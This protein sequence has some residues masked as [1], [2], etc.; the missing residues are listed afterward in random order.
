MAAPRDPPH[1]RQPGCPILRSHYPP[2]PQAVCPFIRINSSTAAALTSV[3][4]SSPGNASWAA[5]HA[6]RGSKTR[7][8][9]GVR[10]FF[11]SNCPLE[12]YHF[13]IGQR[14]GEAQIQ[15]YPLALFAFPFRHSHVPLDF[16]IPLLCSFVTPSRSHSSPPRFE[17]RLAVGSYDR[18]A[19]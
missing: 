8:Y 5:V 3:T 11:Q 16:H 9:Q 6:C 10:R 19:E 4:S 15:V 7:C 17:T 2:R 18:V 14:A 13:G 12:N 1:N